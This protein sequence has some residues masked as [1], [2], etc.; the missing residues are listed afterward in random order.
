MSLPP[1]LPL[2][3]LERIATALERIAASLEQHHS[4][5]DSSSSFTPSD[6]VGT[7]DALGAPE[8]TMT[9]TPFEGTTLMENF[10]RQRGITIKVVPSRDDGDA[11]LDQLAT[12]IG[13]AMLP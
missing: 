13:R 11:I 8:H 4:K 7:P 1:S 6:S 9:Q 12:L 3:I 5:P 10:L 2:Q